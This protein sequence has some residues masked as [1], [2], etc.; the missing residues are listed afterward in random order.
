MIYVLGIGPGEEKQ[1]TFWAHETLLASDVI[2]GYHAYIDLIRDRYPEKTFIATPMKREIERCRLA[3]EEAKSGKA[4]ALVCSGDPGVYGLAGA[5][6]A[7]AEDSGISVT[8]I[9][10]VTAATSAAAVLGAPLIHDF[11]VISLS[12]L[13]TPWDRIEKRLSA[14]GMADFSVCIYN[15]ASHN[16]KDHLKRA[17][18]ILLA[19]RAP[20]TPC[21]WVRNIGRDGQTS[22][23]LTLRELMDETVDMFTT[24]IVGNSQTRIV[25]GRLVTPRGYLEETL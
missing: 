22:K 10:G 23:I 18:E 5:V 11:A 1:S 2:V 24:V 6:L 13:L 15:P 3:L 21:G 20:E 19:W 17:C 8:V 25:D 12:D 9:P 4:V 16:R 14:A 7:L